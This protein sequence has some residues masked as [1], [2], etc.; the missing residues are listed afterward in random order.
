MELAVAL[1]A[2]TLCAKHFLQT[3]YK[4]E[5]KQ[6]LNS[7]HSSIIAWTTVQLFH[8]NSMRQGFL[9]FS[10]HL[11]QSLA[12]SKCL[13]Q[14]TFTVIMLSYRNPQISMAYSNKHLFIAH[15][16]TCTVNCSNSVPGSGLG[17]GLF[18]VSSCARDQAE[19]H[20]GHSILL[21]DSRNPRRLMEIT[22]PLKVST[23][24]WHTSP[25]NTH[26]PL[27]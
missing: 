19:E 3:A 2:Q 8:V 21:A 17:S 14:S 6:C 15:R 12:N 16:S 7:M 25:S 1:R 10:Q 26:I 24:I 20:G 9:L 23:R 27:V 13:Y 18:H 11:E 4:T 22:M 5:K